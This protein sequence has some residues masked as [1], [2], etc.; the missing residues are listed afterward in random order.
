MSDEPNTTPPEDTQ[1]WEAPGHPHDESLEPE[2]E[3][4][5]ERLRAL[6][7]EAEEAPPAPEPKRGVAGREVK[8][9]SPR[10]PARRR[11]AAARGGGR[12]VARIAAP[13]VFLVAVIVL[14]A[15]MFQSG[16]IGDQPEVS[17]S[18][19]PK[20]TS[21]KSGSPAPK[22][23]TK[24]YVVKA[25]DTLS[26]IAVKFNTS[27]SAIEELNPDLSSSTVVAGVKIKVPRN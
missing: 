26:G 3:A 6:S 17:V 10:S 22:G 2:D 8:A 25:G 9:V 4:A 7:A 24:V 12:S 15:L 5:L 18:P 21:T 1:W 20:A 19:T 11:P 23:A 13:A 16:V 27:I 14:V